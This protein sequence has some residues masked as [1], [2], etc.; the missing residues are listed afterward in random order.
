[1]AEEEKKEGEDTAGAAK[2]G[3]KKIIII[4]GVVGLVV[5]GAAAFFLMGGKKEEA[6]AAHVEAESE[7]VHQYQTTELPSI[8]VNLSDPASFL[9]V[10]MLVEYDPE[11]LFHSAHGG[12]EE[13]GGGGGG[14]GHEAKPEGPSKGLPGPLGKREGIVKDSIIRVISSRHAEDLL[15]TEG[16]EKLKEDLI[17]A[18]NEAS[19]LEEP[20]VVGVYFTEFIIQ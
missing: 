4:G 12:K 13:A 6:A 5:I 10:S 19:G 18:V 7:K 3:K 2:G 15:T 17:D 9:K 8:I 1:M 14:G 11:I 20:V 16:K